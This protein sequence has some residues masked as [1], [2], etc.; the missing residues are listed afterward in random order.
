M[1]DKDFLRY[2]LPYDAHVLSGFQLLEFPDRRILES[3]LLSSE[4]SSPGNVSVARVESYGDVDLL[5]T[6]I[7]V[8]C[9]VE[10]GAVG[11]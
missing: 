5:G 8:F 3:L 10:V 7:P 11:I 9:F 2:L 4:T 6:R 1:P